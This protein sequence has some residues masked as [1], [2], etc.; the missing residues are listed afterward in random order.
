M[1]FFDKFKKKKIEVCKS[2]LGGFFIEL[3]INSPAYFTD[4]CKGALYVAT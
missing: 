4:Y 2:F 3:N 1:G